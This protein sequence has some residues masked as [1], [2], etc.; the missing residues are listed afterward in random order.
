[1]K[2]ISARAVS[3]LTNSALALILIAVAAVCLIPATDPASELE[4]D[5][6]R[7]GS[8]EG[9]SLM[10]N[11]YE[12]ADVV[13]QMLDVFEEYGAKVT[14]FLGGCWAD[15][16]VECVK[17]I[18]KRGQEIGSHGYFHLDHGSLGYDANVR[19][20]ATSMRL[21]SLIADRPVELF[22]PPSG[23]YGEETVRAA[24][25]LGVKTILWSRDTVDWRDKDETLCFKRATE[26]VKSGEFILMHP[27]PH[28]LHALPKI[29]SYYAENG[30]RP[31]SVGENLG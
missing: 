24:A 21:L 27:T 7:R 6:F 18:A 4:E 13:Y 1:M 22:A 10:I 9:V 31:L 16:N 23:D 20:I 15:D 28:T 12:G 19:E 3:A 29:L 11:V 5:V 8:G 30:I 2:K 25:A 26:G 14:F 17:E